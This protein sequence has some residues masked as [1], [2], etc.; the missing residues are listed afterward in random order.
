[1]PPERSSFFVL[2]SLPRTG[3]TAI[4]RALN[5][6]RAI[7][8]AFEPDWSDGPFRDDD[9]EVT[10]RQLRASADGMKHV[11]DPSGYPFVK[12]HQSRLPDLAQHADEVIRRNSRI[13]ST[14]DTRI[15]FLRRRDQL[16]RVV[17][18]L[19]GQQTDLWGPH[20]PDGRFTSPAQE[21]RDYRAALAQRT[22]R[23]L[24][25]D[26]IA[27]YLAH[28]SDIESALR[29][30][31]AANPCLDVWYE[32][33]FSPEVGLDARLEHYCHVLR[34]LGFPAEA[35][36]WDRR[37][38]AECVDPAARL[39]SRETLSLIPNWT[40]VTRQFGDPAAASK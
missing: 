18:D 35:G 12:E 8:C 20:V 31:A 29:T 13:V 16:A 23:P 15:V 28:V 25:L 5:A 19:V 39:N 32:D 7:T 34:F 14:A 3:S 17:S 6:H 4:C 26:V 27:W 37:I 10:W 2:F 21:S 1:V 38:V 11:W 30:A 24:P 33:L 36:D 40:E 22:L 9:F